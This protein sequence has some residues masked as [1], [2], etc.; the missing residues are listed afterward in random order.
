MR[1]YFRE[2]A[3]I[4]AVIL[5]MIS[6]GLFYQNEVSS[7]LSGLNSIFIDKRANTIESKIVLPSSF[8]FSLKEK[9]TRTAKS[10][11]TVGTFIV[12]LDV[13]GST[14]IPVA[15]YQIDGIIIHV[16]PKM[17]DVKYSVKCSG[18]INN[19]CE[20]EVIESNWAPQYILFKTSEG[21]TIR[22]DRPYYI[23]TNYI[24]LNKELEI[25]YCN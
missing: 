12:L 3:V 5:T 14:Y 19:S 8:E 9:S 6:I 21:C 16:G 2:M 24:Q 18:T 20:A 11:Q 15:I 7:R 1:R 13:K 10:V 25:R 17:M 22:W 4:F 23:T